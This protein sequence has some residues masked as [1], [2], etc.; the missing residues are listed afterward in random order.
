MQRHDETD[1]IRND[2]LALGIPTGALG[3]VLLFGSAAIALAMILTPI[4][5][6]LAGPQSAAG[7]RLDR[8]ITG[9]TGGQTFYTIRRSILQPS[10]ASVCIIRANGQRSGDC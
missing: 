10:P 4:A 1:L 2:R 8:T 9:S 3:M 6:R 5:E 7:G